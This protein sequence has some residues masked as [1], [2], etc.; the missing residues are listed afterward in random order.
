[1]R[2]VIPSKGNFSTTVNF[3]SRPPLPVHQGCLRQT[4]M[5]SPFLS[6]A[7]LTLLVLWCNPHFFHRFS[8]MN[9]YILLVTFVCTQSNP[10]CWPLGMCY[11]IRVFQS[12]TPGKGE[13]KP[14]PDYAIQ[15]QHTSTQKFHSRRWVRYTENTHRI[16]CLSCCGLV[17][18][19][20]KTYTTERLNLVV[21][22]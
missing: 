3:V 5:P 21:L 13:A 19:W 20:N 18:R 1:M 6:S 8:W 2:D 14:P 22:I 4:F 10:L 17:P 12:L 9:I 16:T 7:L 15:I 11:H